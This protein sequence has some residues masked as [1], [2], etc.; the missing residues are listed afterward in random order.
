MQT[1]RR[2][3]L[4]DQL[5]ETA[6]ALMAEARVVPPM[7]AKELRELATEL[8]RVRVSMLAGEAPKQHLLAWQQ[9]QAA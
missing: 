9:P 7:E 4:A 2:K 8:D 6:L 5:N 1:L 3:R